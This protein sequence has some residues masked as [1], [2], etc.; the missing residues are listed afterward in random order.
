MERQ[1][2]E[3][4]SEFDSDRIETLTAGLRALA[5][6][7]VRSAADADDLVQDTWVTALRHRPDDEGRLGG[8]L[9]KTLRN[10]AVNRR[11][12]EARR[13]RREAA[14]AVPEAGPRDEHEQFET[15]RALLSEVEA[16]E[17]PCR[18]AVRLRFLEGEPPRRIAK[19]LGVP[20]A[21]VHSRIQRGL[22][23]L[24]ERLDARSGGDRKAWLAALLPL[25]RPEGA[26]LGAGALAGMVVLMK[27]QMVAVV[28][29]I[30]LGGGGALALWVAQPDG[31][32][33]VAAEESE[34]LTRS[35]ARVAQLSAE[36][37]DEVERTKVAEPDTELQDTTVAAARV[38]G[39][40]IDDVTG[41]PLE[42]VT[43]R[44][45]GA[46]LAT[47]VDGR[48]EFVVS[49]AP[50]GDFGL[51]LSKEGYAMRT[52][53]WLAFEP[54]QV[55][56][57][58]DVV[59]RVGYRV[60]GLVLGEDGLPRD[61]IRVR[62][63]GLPMPVRSSVAANDSL[64]ATS[65]SDGRIEWS[66]LVP[67]GTWKLEVPRGYLLGQRS[68]SVPLEEPLVL[69]VA[70][71]R[72]LRGR[73]VDEAGQPMDGLFIRAES[74]EGR[75]AEAS[76]T[77]A[78]G[79]F[80][81]R[82]REPDAGAPAVITVADSTSRRRIVF[83]RREITSDWGDDGLEVVVQR[84]GEL[85][86]RVV[87]DEDG[88]PVE[89]YSVRLHPKD[90]RDHLSGES[91]RGGG[92]HPG[93]SLRIAGLE[94]GENVLVVHPE[95]PR[96]L[97]SFPQTIHY[98]GESL[99]V[100]VVV[101]LIRSVAI[102]ARVFDAAGEPVPAAKVQLIDPGV[103]QDEPFT[104]SSTAFMRTWVLQDVRT[105][106]S[107][108]RPNRIDEKRTDGSGRC[109]LL[110]DPRVKGPVAV[111]VQ[112]EGF[113]TALIWVDAS[114]DHGVEIRLLPAPSVFGRVLPELLGRARPILQLVAKDGRVLVRDPQ[115]N[116]D[117]D[118]RFLFHGVQPGRY[119]LRLAVP[120]PIG[121]SSAAPLRWREPLRNDLEVAP[122][123]DVD[124]GE[125]REDFRPAT[126]TGVIRTGKRELPNASV[127]FVATR[128]SPWE[129]MLGEFA[130]DKRGRFEVRELPPGRWQPFV[131]VGG[132]GDRCASWTRATEVLEVRPGERAEVVLG[133]PRRVVRA[134]VVDAEGRPLAGVRV[135]VEFTEHV[136]G[137]RPIER[138]TDGAG[139]ISLDPAPDVPFQFRVDGHRLLE[140]GQ[141]VV[142][143]PG[144]C[145]EGEPVEIVLRV[146]ER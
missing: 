114:V 31:T 127:W 55:Q 113:R 10:L 141:P 47:G 45:E 80:V 77:D 8:W 140:P 104:A 84:T 63:L 78:E 9:R 101:R 57:L 39:R 60:E 65:G 5:R 105:S 125:L 92:V 64:A 136:E 124:V 71:L 83:A 134:R 120:Q 85:E 52:G 22:A 129:G 14:A 26:L 3:P 20:V 102:E 99:D 35:E 49:P 23:R 34:V 119:E 18:S 41:A 11:I 42:G 131:A 146:L 36:V 17:E 88:K 96:W 51:H 109:T 48:F 117:G 111:Q 40:C 21:T 82:Q 38:R 108:R 69:R 4:G 143:E 32:R 61:R 126:V 37:G 7:L 56:D 121:S 79:R 145:G 94:A 24:R 25:A 62:L 130:V 116:V 2:P 128:D 66:A 89:S 70:D 133:L 118:G 122:E 75:E 13:A 54:Q 72:E 103:G 87:D 44:F 59:L 142:V 106:E 58:G 16:L 112:S 46:T 138:P 73:V 29:M 68:L 19:R 76:S 15:L 33:A 6:G 74:A 137:G 95:D 30:V 1:Q 90:G 139:E 27:T 12:D 144:D 100:P 135:S 81:I 98:D 67:A 28:A 86:L 93:G 110:H 97:E 91:P 53:R 50:R 123:G 43:V 132:E 115:A 107:W